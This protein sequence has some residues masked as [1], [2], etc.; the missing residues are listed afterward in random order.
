MPTIVTFISVAN[1]VLNEVERLSKEGNYYSAKTT[2]D[3][4]QTSKTLNISVAE[5]K[6][7]DKPIAPPMLEMNMINPD[8]SMKAY[9]LQNT[10]GSWDLK[11]STEGLMK[12]TYSV[13]LW[14]NTNTEKFNISGSA[15]VVV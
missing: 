4:N 9:P 11:I 1:F 13:N 12:G 2:V 5:I 14:G 10:G 3:Y 8:K 15:I 7:N 6:K